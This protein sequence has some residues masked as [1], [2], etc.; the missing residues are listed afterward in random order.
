MFPTSSHSAVKEGVLSSLGPPVLP[1][2]GLVCPRPPPPPPPSSTGE[3]PTR[4]ES[5]LDILRESCRSRTFRG[6]DCIL[7]SVQARS[8][9]LL[10]PPATAVVAAAEATTVPVPVPLLPEGLVPALLLLP[11]FLTWAPVAGL[12][13]A[14]VAPGPGWSL[15]F[16]LTRVVKMVR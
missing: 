13:W 10:L 1:F 5:D 8:S 11:P 15:W 12:G 9:K 16:W 6:T 4:L 3:V 2:P 14:L 7:P